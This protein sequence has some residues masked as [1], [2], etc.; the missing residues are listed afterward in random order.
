MHRVSMTPSFAG[1]YG[2]ARRARP[3]GTLRSSPKRPDLPQPL[4]PTTLSLVPSDGRYGHALNGRGASGRTC[5]D[6]HSDGAAQR[7]RDDRQGAGVL[8][9]G[10]GGD[11]EQSS[12]APARRSPARDGEAGPLPL[13]PTAL[14]GRR[15]SD[16]RPDDGG[17][18][19][20]QRLAAAP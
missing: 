7:P 1:E 19:P 18:R 16:R 6:S 9:G 3:R 15:P 14:R 20:I 11:S 2:Q 8:R 5:P 4:S 17:R 13:L 10:D 12:L